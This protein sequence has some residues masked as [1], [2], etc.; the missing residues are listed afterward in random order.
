VQIDM[1]TGEQTWFKTKWTKKFKSRKWRSSHT[2]VF[3]SSKP[4]ILSVFEDDMTMKTFFGSFSFKNGEI[5]AID[6]H[7]SVI[8]RSEKSFTNIKQ[9]ENGDIFCLSYHY[10]KSK[11]ISIAVQISID[12]KGTISLEGA[13]RFSMDGGWYIPFIHNSYY[14]WLSLH[15][16]SFLQ[17]LLRIPFDEESTEEI[18]LRNDITGSPDGLLSLS[19]QVEVVDE[20]IFIYAYDKMKKRSVLLHFDLT[21]KCVQKIY[22]EMEHHIVASS[23]QLDHSRDGILYLSGKCDD[24]SCESKAHICIIDFRKQYLVNAFGISVSFSQK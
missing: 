8:I 24:E 14:Y 9:D 10:E 4:F 19:T 6:E 17:R 5:F 3:R 21:E 15:P 11:T 23:A 20:R 1:S 13:K 12:E 2:P 16:D 22:V 18:E 7:C